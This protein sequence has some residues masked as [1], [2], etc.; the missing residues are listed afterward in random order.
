MINV[1]DIISNLKKFCFYDKILILKIKT[2]YSLPMNHWC[3]F[4]SQF[5]TDSIIPHFNHLSFLCFS[6]IFVIIVPLFDCFKWALQKFS[7]DGHS[8]LVA[9][10]R[11]LT[12][13]FFPGVFGSH[14]GCP[15]HNI[16]VFSI[17]N[18]KQFGSLRNIAAKSLFRIMIHT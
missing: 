1:H 4:I 5:W 9:I 13:T 16:V 12:S 15:L 3:F 10:W 18:V 11:A 14:F 7:A 8:S 6:L 2:Q 17:V